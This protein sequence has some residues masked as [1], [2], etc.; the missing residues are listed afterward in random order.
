MKKKIPDIVVLPI[1]KS[2]PFTYEGRLAFSLAATLGNVQVSEKAKEWIYSD[3]VQIICKK[4]VDGHVRHDFFHVFHP[5]NPFLKRKYSLRIKKLWIDPEKALNDVIS[6]LSRGYFVHI[7]LDLSKTKVF[8][9]YEK[10]FVH[11]EHIYGYDKKKEILYFIRFDY[12]NGLETKELSFQDFKNS[13][14]P[15]IGEDQRLINIYDRVREKANFKINKKAL[16]RRIVDYSNSRFSLIDFLLMQVKTL[17]FAWDIPYGK[18]VG[19]SAINSVVDILK[20]ELQEKDWLKLYGQHF[21]SRSRLHAICEFNKLM[22]ER[23]AYMLNNNMIY[24]TTKSTELINEYKKLQDKY[25]IIRN[26]Y[27]KY[28]IKHERKYIIEIISE[29]ENL[30]KEEVRIINELSRFFVV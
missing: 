19:T 24:E 3:F 6:H 10:R 23:F 21:Q 29:L 17:V 22:I 8:G 1:T 26:K 12:R 13:Y 2:I 30:Q 5:F 9:E 14:T 11:S 15:M 18:S 27:L 4:K 28:Q 7:R 25:L 20:L 16:Y